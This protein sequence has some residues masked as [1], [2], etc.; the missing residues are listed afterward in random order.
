MRQLLWTLVFVLGTSALAQSEPET[1]EKVPF[2]RKPTGLKL[3]PGWSKKVKFRSALQNISLP[4]H[5]DWRE[6]ATLPPPRDQGDCGSCWAHSTVGV[7]ESA[8]A[9]KDKRIVDLSEQFL[10]SCNTRGWN[11]ASGGDFAHDYHVNPGAV[12]EQDFPYQARDG[13]PC[14]QGLSHPYKID[15]WAF[16]PSKSEDVPPEIDEIKAA[17]YQFGPVAAAIGAN[18][19]LSQY[20][21][22]VFN[23]CD[24]TQPNHAIVLTGWDED[25]GYWVMRNSWGNW[26]D[27][28]YGKIRYNCNYVGLGANYI[29]F[30]SAKPIPTPGPG[31]APAPQPAPTPQPQPLPKCVPQ[32]YANAGNNYRIYPGQWVVLGTNAMPQTAYMWEVNGR[33]NPRYNTARL[34]AQVFADAIFTV[35]ATTKCGTARSS[36]M[37]IVNRRR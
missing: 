5:F 3:Q 6:Q 12:W 37:V 20:R 14:K 23:G 7:L 21:S 33:S 28:G 27:K 26:G 18:N 35:Y 4:R 2:V 32:P 13:V 9:I 24:G 34:R 30:E 29:M 11:C 19:A 16:V 15:S 17:I 25:G 22:G 8:I 36:A 10:V 31:P 1:F